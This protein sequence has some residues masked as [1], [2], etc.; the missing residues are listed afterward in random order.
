MADIQRLQDSRA[1]LQQHGWRIPQRHSREDQRQALPGG[2]SKVYLAII[3]LFL[4][5]Y[6]NVSMKGRRESF[7]SHVGD[8]LI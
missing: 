3:E 4:N 8:V 5:R 1:G 6:E 7:D 2:V